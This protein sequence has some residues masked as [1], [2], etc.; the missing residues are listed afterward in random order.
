MWVCQSI[1]F[2]YCF[3]AEHLFINISMRLVCTR[4]F[5]H[6]ARPHCEETHPLFGVYSASL[7]LEQVHET[8]IY[9][10]FLILKITK[11]YFDE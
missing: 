9:D 5:W 11:Y 4:I 1:S 8:K 2:F 3:T 6:S 10:K 7:I